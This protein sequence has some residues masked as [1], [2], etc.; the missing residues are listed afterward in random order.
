MRDTHRK[1]QRH[2]QR[3]KQ[4]PCKKP[5]VGLHPNT[6]GS[7][8]EPNADAQPLSHPDITPVVSSSQLLSLSEILLFIYLF[9]YT[10]FMSLTRI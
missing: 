9:C 2:R 5:D 4:A 10:L 8:P 6:P 1:R 3:E 7:C